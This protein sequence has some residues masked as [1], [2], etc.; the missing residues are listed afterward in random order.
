VNATLSADCQN[1]FLSF[2][3]SGDAADIFDR[4]LKRLILSGT[5]DGSE[6]T[7]FLRAQLAALEEQCLAL[8]CR[9]KRLELSAA[10]TSM[11]ISS[12]ELSAASPSAQKVG[13]F[14]KLFSGRVDVF[15]VRWENSGTGRSDYAPACRNEWVRGVCEK[16]Q[17]KYG[18]CPNQAFIP[19]SD[20]SIASHL[21]GKAAAWRG[22]APFVCGV[23]PLLADDTCRFLAVDFDGEEWAADALAFFE[24]CRVEGGRQGIG[25]SVTFWSRW[26]GIA[27]SQA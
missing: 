8:K 5:D 12:P 16:P 6:N 11:S 14:R 19:V 13:L 10:Q 21:R 1:L 24:T 22:D 18:E 25:R 17:V 26:Q 2:A 9:L 4:A 7:A 20:D 27:Q 15:P 23:Y 3:L